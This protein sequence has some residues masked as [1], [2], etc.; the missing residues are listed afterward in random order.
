MTQES[1]TAARPI[2]LGEAMAEYLSTVKPELRSSYAQTI[3]R[4][5]EYA[6]E[7]QLVSSLTG[8]RVE[9]YAENQIKPSDPTAPERVAALKA[10]FQYLKRKDYAPANFGVHIRVRRV[11]GRSAASNNAPVQEERIEM[12]A[13]GLETLKRQYDELAS[14]QAELIQAVETARSDG[15]LRENAPYHAAREALSFHQQ[16]M[17]DIEHS[18][19]RAVVVQARD[20]RSSVGSVVSVTNL[21]T[22][23]TFDYT[24]VSAREA[25]AAQQ[26]ISVESPV[27]R[28]LLGRRVGEEVLVSTPRGESRFRVEAVKHA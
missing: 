14:Q 24:L 13:D 8:S 16:K 12:T 1:E 25:N 6:G 2:T 20:E 10:W 22:N 5:V 27:G 4:F 18:L 11:A 28:Q 9:L 3:R 7:S 19:A 23:K 26:R 15:D 21:D 17:K